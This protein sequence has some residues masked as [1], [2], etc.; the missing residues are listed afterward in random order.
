M[1]LRIDSL[2]PQH[3][4]SFPIMYRVFACL[5]VAILLFEILHQTFQQCIMDTMLDSGKIKS[6]IVRCG[7]ANLFALLPKAT[8][9]N[10]LVPCRNLFMMRTC[11]L[12]SFF[13]GAGART[14]GQIADAF[15]CLSARPPAL[16]CQGLLA[17]SERFCDRRRALNRRIE[18]RLT[19]MP[20][21]LIRRSV[22]QK[23]WRMSRYP[24]LRKPSRKQTTS[25]R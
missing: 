24:F 11:G 13:G 25:S 23:P 3:C 15:C 2:H 5:A 18:G 1:L 16:E 21:G 6:C 4:V 20:G 19:I 7:V 17:G 9:Q 14:L 8:K 12:V 22:C 10:Q